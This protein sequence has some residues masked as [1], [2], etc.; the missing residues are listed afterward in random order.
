[1]KISLLLVVCA[2]FCATSGVATGAPGMDSPPV[3]AAQHDVFYVGGH[4]EDDHGKR[5]MVGQMFV[6]AITP[7]HVTHPIPLVL[8]HG[9]AQTAVNWMATPDG[10]EGWA[11]WFARHGWAV[12]IVD[13]PARGRSAWNPDLQPTVSA[14]PVELVEKLFTD[15]QAYAAWPQA[16][17]HTQW[18]GTGRAGDPAF[19]QFYAGEVPSLGNAPSETMMQ[20]AGAALLDRIGPAIIV[21]HSQ[22]GAF[23]WLIADARPRLVRGIVALE[24]LGPPYKDSVFQTGHDRLWGLTDVPLT[25]DPSVTDGSPLNFVQD[26]TPDAADLAACWK[27]AAPVRALPNLKGFPVLVATT[28]ASYHAVYDHC[29]AAYLKQ[30]GVDVDFER[31]AEHGIEGN[32]HMMMLE[33]NSLA[34]AAWLDG[35]MTERIH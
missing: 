22:A 28:Q 17:L 13:Q 5:V 3:L 7:A 26:A 34:I 8:I 16:K 27:Q 4:Y 31:L 25:Y 24:P 14:V 20:Q 9:L 12:Y 32:G 19:D 30:A 21:T 2:A 29:T 18:P 23:G 10:R 11:D 1:M 15:P 35:W 6:E 33:K